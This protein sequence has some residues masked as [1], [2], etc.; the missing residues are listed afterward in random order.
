MG[1]RDTIKTSDSTDKASSW[2]DTIK[3]APQEQSLLGSIG[4]TISDGVESLSDGFSLGLK[5]EAAGLGG[6]VGSFLMGDGFRKGYDWG[7]GKENDK[8]AEAQERSPVAS[9]ITGM[10][11]AMMS[12]G[13]LKSTGLGALTAAGAQGGAIAGFGDSDASLMD[14]D[15]AGVAKDTAIGGSIGAALP[16]VFKGI[17]K[18]A[19]K[20]GDVIG[21]SKFGQAFKKGEAVR[22]FNDPEQQTDLANKLLSSADDVL[23][24][25]YQAQAAARK[26]FATEMGNEA[27]DTAPILDDLAAFAGRHG[28]EVAGFGKLTAG[29]AKKLGRYT[30]AL[31]EPQDAKT[32]YAIWDDINR[33]KTKF[34]A[35]L[36]GNTTEYSKRLG[37]LMK[38]IKSQLHGM[39]DE[40][41]GADA[42]TSKALGIRDQIKGLNNNPEAFLSSLGSRNKG[43]RRAAINELLQKKYG[44]V[45]EEVD[46]FQTYKGFQGQGGFGSDHGL[47]TGASATAGYAVAGPPGAIAMGIAAS[48]RVQMQALTR[49]GDMVKRIQSKLPS[50]PPKYQQALQ[51][52]AQRGGNATAVTHFLMSNQDP[53]Y[54]QLM[55]DED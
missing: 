13:P 22:K 8:L 33:V 44:N 11:G 38:G 23:G 49:S 39:S 15:I 40:L 50:L 14:G 55:E 27:A 52:A 6:G 37:Q 17:G 20:V 30:D 43:N 1:W 18:G 48:K 25:T 41:S 31:Q 19:G 12:G 9:A 29:E 54:R 42:A 32:L 45:L 7:K 2:R 47:Q 53:E 26:K 34:E 35:N 4:D 24:D 28:E 16:S 5:D 10:G 36:N 46:N 21:D 51:A 3:D